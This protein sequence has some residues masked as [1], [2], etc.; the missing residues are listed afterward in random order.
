[1]NKRRSDLEKELA[2]AGEAAQ[3]LEKLSSA[4]STEREECVSWLLDSPRNVEAFLHVSAVD[5]SLKNVDPEKSIEVAGGSAESERCNVVRFSHPCQDVPPPDESR[6]PRKRI[7]GAGFRK[8]G[9]IP[10]DDDNGDD[11]ELEADSTK[12]RWAPR[13]RAFAAGGAVLAVLAA[14]LLSY[15]VERPAEWQRYSTVGSERSSFAL[16]DGSLLKL[17]RATTVEVRYSGK[18]RELRLESGEAIFKVRH[19]TSRPFNVYAGNVFVQA[20]G[21][22]FAVE[23]RSGDAVVAVLEGKVRVEGHAHTQSGPQELQRPAFDPV[24]IRSSPSHANSRDER[25]SATHLF[26]TA[27]EEARVANDGT[28]EERGKADLARLDSWR[29]HRLVFVN[30]SLEHVIAE[31]NRFNPQ[32]QIRIEG[33]GTAA[34]QFFTMSFNA[35]DPESMLAVLERN[36]ALQVEHSGDEV[37]IR[38]K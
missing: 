29:E 31:F 22:E 17:N 9:D 27:G 3:W 13:W 8:F 2:A 12:R 19:D 23:R 36:P 5:A 4:D 1:M 10:G 6:E 24:S 28:L 26:L 38:R 37:V 30:E 25:G 18:A 11:D 33:S 35:E 16:A 15:N 32:L 14:G 7:E 34:G 20:V 21:T